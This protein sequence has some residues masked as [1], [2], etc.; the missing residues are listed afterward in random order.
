MRIQKQILYT[1]GS[2]QYSF[3]FEGCKSTYIYFIC[4]EKLN[5]TVKYNLVK[6]WQHLNFK[7]L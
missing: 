2:Y 3:I 4:F 7:D 5:H 1:N 6:L